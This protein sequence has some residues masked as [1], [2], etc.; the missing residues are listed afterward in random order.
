M[1]EQWVQ[2][3]NKNIWEKIREKVCRLIRI[4]QLPG[5]W[6]VYY[7]VKMLRIVIVARKVAIVMLYRM[8]L[9]VQTRLKVS[10]TS[11]VI[12]VAKWALQMVNKW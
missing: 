2:I 12:W 1:P 8:S 7:A 9:R 10:L 3:H 6:I 5:N 4:W 11:L